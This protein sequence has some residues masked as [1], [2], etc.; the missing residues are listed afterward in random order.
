MELSEY[1]IQEE[2][3][4]T[5]IALLSREKT[6]FSALETMRELR[7]FWRTEP[8]DLGLDRGDLLARLA[9]TIEVTEL[10]IERGGE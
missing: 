5:N 8:Q 2:T 1:I 9:Q 7:T 6:L 4:V 10:V 3:L